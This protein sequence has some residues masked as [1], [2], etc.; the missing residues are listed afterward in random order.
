MN[1]T[2]GRK[3]L[4]ALFMPAK[5]VLSVRLALA[6]ID[7]RGATRGQSQLP[8]SLKRGFVNLLDP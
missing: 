1:S 2:F 7:D 8:S 3:F 6:L 4:I 5:L